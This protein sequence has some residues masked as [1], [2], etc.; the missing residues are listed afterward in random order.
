M[1]YIFEVGM[2]N[3][4]KDWAINNKWKRMIIKVKKEASH[5]RKTLLNR[6]YQNGYERLYVDIMIKQDYG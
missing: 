3:S 2:I 6:N 4:A 1:W 5:N